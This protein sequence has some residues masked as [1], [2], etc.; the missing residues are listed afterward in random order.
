MINDE[1]RARAQALAP[2]LI[3]TRRHIH[4]H[5][6]LGDEEYETQKFIIS[7]LDEYGIEHHEYPNYTAVVGIIRGGRPGK[8]VGL[9][10]DID[11]L[12][13]TEQPGREYGSCTPGKMHACGHDDTAGRGQAA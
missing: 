12:P 13:L 9:R 2:E 11:A 1:L 4:M 10:A 8:T 7:K 6:E 3:K 5:P